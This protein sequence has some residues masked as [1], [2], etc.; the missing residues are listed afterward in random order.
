QRIDPFEEVTIAQRGA[1][2]LQGIEQ[3]IGEGASLLTSQRELF[4]RLLGTARRKDD[5]ATSGQRI[6]TTRPFTRAFGRA[7]GCGLLWADQKALDRAQPVVG[8]YAAAAY[9]GLLPL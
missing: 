1:A 3:V 8:G 5:M 6:P 7:E 4:G 9:I 2:A